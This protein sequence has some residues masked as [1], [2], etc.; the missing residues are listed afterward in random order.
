MQAYLMQIL[1]EH[2]EIVDAISARD[3]RAAHAAMRHHLKGS[4]AR[5]ESLALDRR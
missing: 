1:Q 2:K 4:Q 5:Y 3:A